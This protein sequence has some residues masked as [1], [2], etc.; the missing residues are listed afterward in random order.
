LDNAVDDE[1]RLLNDEEL[2]NFGDDWRRI[3]DVM[4]ELVG[5]NFEYW[6]SNQPHLKEAEDGLV[7]AK[8]Y[9]AG[10]DMQGESFEWIDELQNDWPVTATEANKII[11]GLLRSSVHQTCVVNYLIVEDKTALETEQLLLVFLDG[12]GRVVRQTRLGPSEAEDM[13]GSW[14]SL[15]WYEVPEWTDGEIGEDYQE[16]GVCGNLLH[17]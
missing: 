5:Y 1:D 16:G 11:L 6:Q 12:K 2:Y 8:A 10:D 9:L 17:L 7:K 15:S 4:P 13:G 14:L 3:L